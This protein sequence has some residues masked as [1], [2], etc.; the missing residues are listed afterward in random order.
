MDFR[1]MRRVWRG[2][3]WPKDWRE[4]VIVPIVKRGR[5]RK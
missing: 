1:F 5:A 4:G 2:E 3:G